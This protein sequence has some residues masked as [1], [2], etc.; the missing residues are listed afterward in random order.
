MNKY[1][2]II[3]EAINSTILNK[4]IGEVERL[5]KDLETM[6]LNFYGQEIINFVEKIKKVGWNVVNLSTNKTSVVQTTNRFKRKLFYPNNFGNTLSKYGFKI[7]NEGLTNNVYSNTVNTYNWTQDLL[8]NNKQKGKKQQDPTIR[9]KKI[10]DSMWP[11]IFT[12]Y[13]S[14]V[15][16]Y[17]YV[18]QRPPT[19]VSLVQN[20]EEIYQYIK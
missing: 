5:L 3:T 15:S 8:G 11:Q 10:M 6:N 4:R 19:L 12:E 20:L 18:L 2:R 17:R 1:N 13:A 16:R 7:P 14:I 9:I